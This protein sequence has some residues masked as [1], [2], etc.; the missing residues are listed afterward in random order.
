M[1]PF[2]DVVA[3]KNNVLLIVDETQMLYEQRESAFWKKL[4]QLAQE[5]R[6]HPVRV[7][8]LAAYSL[9]QLVRA[10]PSGRPNDWCRLTL[11]T[12]PRALQSPRCVL[13][14][15]LP[16]LSRIRCSHGRRKSS[17]AWPTR[18]DAVKLT[19]LTV[20]ADDCCGT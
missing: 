11:L 8:L 15:G 20:R 4:K 9:D 17:C 10:Q 6:M 3:S 2:N 14:Q 13:T 5:Q 16:C 18:G 1:L 12:P 7:F 19:C